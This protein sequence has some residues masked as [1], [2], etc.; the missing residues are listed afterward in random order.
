MYAR[1]I[2]SLCSIVFLRPPVGGVVLVVCGAT[3]QGFYGPNTANNVKGQS[4][5]AIEFSAWTTIMASAGYVV[6]FNIMWWVRL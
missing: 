6:G 3:L 1:E 2:R 4:L 5:F